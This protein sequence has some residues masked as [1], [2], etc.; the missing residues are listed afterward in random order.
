[1]PLTSDIPT[2]YGTLLW[3]CSNGNMLLY[4]QIQVFGITRHLPT[5][6]EAVQQSDWS[7]KPCAHTFTSH[8][9]NLLL[10]SQSLKL[11]DCTVY[12]D[13]FFPCKCSSFWAVDSCLPQ[14]FGPVVAM[15]C[16][17]AGACDVALVCGCHRMDQQWKKHPNNGHLNKHMIIWS[18]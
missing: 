6:E 12:I 5:K 1:M 9:S 16:V 14:V 11:P 8:I 10:V 17:V 4:G 2:I 3:R 18:T 15:G 13:T 7:F